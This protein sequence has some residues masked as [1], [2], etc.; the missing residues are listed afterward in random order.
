MRA[1]L[2]PTQATTSPFLRQGARRLPRTRWRPHPRPL[3][4]ADELCTR[5]RRAPAPDTRP[6]GDRSYS[7]AIDPEAAA[8]EV[9]G[10]VDRLGVDLLRGTIEELSRRGHRQITV[11][12]Q[13][14]DD[15]DACAR[16]VLAEVAQGLVG[17]RGRLTMRWSTAAQDA[18]DG[19]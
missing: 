19:F 17:R 12:V 7:E 14:P 9:R 2:P 4:E 13:H 15:V 16:A 6:G 10:R 5:T 3:P 8:I 11:T 18:V 1:E